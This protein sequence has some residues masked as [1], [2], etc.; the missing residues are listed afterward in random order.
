VLKI[1]RH[2][3]YNLLRNLNINSIQE[4]LSLSRLYHKTGK[5][6]QSIKVSIVREILAGRESVSSLSRD[7]HISR[8]TIYSWLEKYKKERKIKDNYVSGHDHPRAYSKEIEGKILREVVETPELAINKIAKKLDLSTHGVFNVLKRHRLTYKDLRIAYATAR[9]EEIKEPAFTWLIDRIRLVLDQFIPTLAPA[10]PPSVKEVYRPLGKLLKIFISSTFSTL[11]VSIA[12]LYWIRVA[13]DATV[14]QLIGYGFAAFAL[15][16]GSIFFL[17]SLKYYITL[18]IVLSFSQKSGIGLYKGKTNGTSSLL[19]R[20]LGLSSR[21]GKNGHIGPVGLEPDLRHITIKRYPYISIHI[22]FYNEKNVAKRLITAT[23]NFDYKGEYE[24]IIAD[25]S[26]DKTVEIVREYQRQFLVKGEKLKEVKGDGWTLTQV[27]VQPGVTLKHLHRTTRSG[28][29]GGA[30]QLALKLSDPRTEFVSVFDADFVPYP[31]TLQLFLKYFKVQNNMS[32]DYSSSDVAVV[33]GYQWHVLNKSENWITR[34]VRCEYAGSYVIERPGREILG[35]LK[36]ISGSVYMIRKDVLQ[37]LGWGTSITEDFQLT[38]RLYEAGYK[39]VFTPYIQAPAECVS[40][41]RRLIRQRMR[42]AEGH[43]NNVRRM[44]MRLMSS[45][46]LTFSEKLEFAYLTPY[47]LQAFFFIIGTISW[48]TSESIFKVKLPFWT[49]LW[50]WSLVLT[51][52][53]SLP[54][55]NAVGLFLEEA[56]EKDYSG[57]LS[58]IALSYIVVPFQAYASLKGFIKKQEGPWFRTPK[59]GKITDVFARGR[60][61][62]FIAGIFPRRRVTGVVANRSLAINRLTNPVKNFSPRK[63]HIRIFTKTVSVVMLIMTMTI[64]TSAGGVNLFLN[65]DLVE[66]T[67]KNMVLAAENSASNGL[68]NVDGGG[69][70]QAINNKPAITLTSSLDNE[71]MVNASKVVTDDFSKVNAKQLLNISKH[72]PETNPEEFYVS[73]EDLVN[74][75]T[76]DGN[77]ISRVGSISRRAYTKAID[78]ALATIGSSQIL[79]TRG[80]GHYVPYHVKATKYSYQVTLKAADGYQMYE[81]T[82]HNLDINLYKISPDG[83]KKIVASSKPVYQY[84]DKFGDWQDYLVKPTVSIDIEKDRNKVILSQEY[85]LLAKNSISEKVNGSTEIILGF[86]GKDYISKASFELK[87]N[88]NLNRVKWENNIKDAGVP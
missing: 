20:I 10:P 52:L 5:L 22:P 72:T 70:D 27:Q 6:E 37:E 26:T 34:G 40:T 25:D 53:L 11:L 67:S 39:V 45:S 76:E 38:L 30:L 86:D 4:R 17:Y 60:F 29:K 18:A 77:F 88:D 42:W 75:E 81:V 66:N 61:Y 65:D 46:T 24:V 16:M 87:D 19:A 82:T 59:T 64:S 13:K 43:S 33:Q 69:V 74:M 54:L 14:L 62:R 63:K 36:Q 35:A 68:G 73:I 41:I 44:F 78:A 80:D 28:F 7:Y 47:Y 15:F 23:T 32:E 48:L 71:D 84:K 49:S 8:K 56:E 3:T 1:G 9:K 50:G 83:T 55:M 12:L 31:D 2:A 57:I 85:T 51:N 79:K 21:N 58:F